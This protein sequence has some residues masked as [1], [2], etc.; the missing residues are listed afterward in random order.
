MQWDDKKPI[1]LQVKEKMA[2]AIMDGIYKEGSLAPSTRELSAE[3]MINPLTV[4][5]AYH[6]LVDEGILTSVRGKGMEVQSGAAQLLKEQLRQAFLKEE[7]PQIK[8]HILRL[9]IELEE[10]LNEINDRSE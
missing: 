4:S 1:Y 10:L 5:K 6:A 3:L 8:Q 9:D 2:A 7:W